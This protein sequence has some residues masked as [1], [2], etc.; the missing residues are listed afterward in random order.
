VT[1]SAGSRGPI[2]QMWMET[3]QQLLFGGL[4]PFLREGLSEYRRVCLSRYVNSPH[5]RWCRDTGV[6]TRV[7]LNTQISSSAPIQGGI[8]QNNCTTCTSTA[9]ATL[10]ASEASA[11]SSVPHHRVVLQV[12]SAL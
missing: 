2:H 6:H 10:D 4:S 7:H 1:D 8:P 5:H 3:A 12:C 11:S 9:T